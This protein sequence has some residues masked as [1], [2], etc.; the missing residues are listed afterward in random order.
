MVGDVLDLGRDRFIRHG[1]RRRARFGVRVARHHVFVDLLDE[2]PPCSC[3]G[4]G[5]TVVCGVVDEQT[6][7]VVACLVGVVVEEL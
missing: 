1:R 3:D 6:Y 7:I 4:R 5:V 2:V